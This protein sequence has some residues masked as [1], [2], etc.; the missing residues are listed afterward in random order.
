MRIDKMSEVVWFD[1]NDEVFA[2]ADAEHKPVL[3]A[4]RVAWCSSCAEMD[5]TS[6][7]EPS[8]IKLISERF[9]PIRVDADRRPDINERYSLGV[10][11]QRRYF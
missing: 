5:R 4:I 10:V 7:S 6:Y 2:R 3:L 11:G 8:I 1:W 9:I